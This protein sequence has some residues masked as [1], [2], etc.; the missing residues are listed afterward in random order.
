MQVAKGAP[1]GANKAAGNPSYTAGYK[2]LGCQNKP[3]KGSC[4]FGDLCFDKHSPDDIGNDKGREKFE[5]ASA[6]YCNRGYPSVGPKGYPK[7]GGADGG[8][9]PRMNSLKIIFK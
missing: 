3:Q 8:K 2:V 1:K 7:G 5:T 4:G 6:N 9:N